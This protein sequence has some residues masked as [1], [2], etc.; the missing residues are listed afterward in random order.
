MET[1]FRHTLI[2][3]WS[4]STSTVST[5]NTHGLGL[6]HGCGKILQNWDKPIGAFKSI[7]HVLN[8]LLVDELLSM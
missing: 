4:E 2:L 8:A 5:D 3:Y 7:L 6:E 1:T